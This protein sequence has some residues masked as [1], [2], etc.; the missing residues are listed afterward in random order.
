MWRGGPAVKKCGL[1]SLARADEVVLAK[2][3]N[4]LTSTT[5]SAPSKEAGIFL[6]VAATPPLLRRG[7]ARSCRISNAHIHLNWT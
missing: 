6:D 5:P 4:F 2:R 1:A 7:V 3:M